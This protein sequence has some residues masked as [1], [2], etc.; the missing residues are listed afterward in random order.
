MKVSVGEKGTIEV[1]EMYNPISLVE[2]TDK[3]SVASRDNGL[4]LYYNGSVYYLV[5]GEIRKAEQGG[6]KEIFELSQSNSQ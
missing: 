2:G 3:F 6:D 5:E 1:S 4:E